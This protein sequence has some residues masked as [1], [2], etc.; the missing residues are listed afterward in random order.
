MIFL[1]VATENLQDLGLTYTQARI[2]LAVL[3]DNPCTFYHI[4]K[5]TGIARSEVYRETVYLE[6]AGLVE[7][8]LERPA[9]VKAMPIEV[10]LKN[11]VKWKEREC[12]ERISK[13]E[14]SFNEFMRFNVPK[15]KRNQKLS[16][17]EV[18]FSLISTKQAI[19]AKTESMI[20]EAEAEVILRYLPRKMCAFLDFCDD[21]INSALRKQVNINLLTKNEEF[22]EGFARTIQSTL[23][24]N[25]RTFEVGYI[26]N[27]PFG[28]TFIDKK[29]LLIETKTEAVFSEKPMLWTDNEI[30]VSIMYEN[31]YQSWLNCPSR[32]KPINQPLLRA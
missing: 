28:L 2:Y 25:Y 29:Q 22:N 24:V 31:V 9:T 10:A 21:S 3:S 23:G 16:H 18:Q 15:L 6:Q 7:K 8:G 20:E 26:T 17:D 14:S 1:G 12:E 27:I 11:F 13:L 30:L 32:L 5:L 4:S 19:L